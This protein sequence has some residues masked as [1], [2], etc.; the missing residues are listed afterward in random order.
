MRKSSGS[1]VA[2]AALLFVAGC[3]SLSPQSPPPKPLP[4]IGA[5]TAPVGGACSVQ[6]AQPFVGQ[7]ATAKV[8][9][10]ARVR[11]GARMAR[12]VRAGQPGT[13][14]HFPDRL[15]LVVDQGGKITGVNCG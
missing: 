2:A 14:E 3:S 12:I 5:S 1:W 9:E 7:K 8:T 11:S 15:N 13:M 10:Q 4:P 6:G